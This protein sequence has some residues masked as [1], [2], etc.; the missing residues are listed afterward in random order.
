MGEELEKK[1]EKMIR[2]LSQRL[3]DVGE[4]NYILSLNERRI[5][6][7]LIKEYFKERKEE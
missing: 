1:Y 3:H 4:A 2:D 6:L 5:V 7:F